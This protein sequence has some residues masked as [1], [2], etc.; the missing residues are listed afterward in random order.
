MLFVLPPQKPGMEELTIW[1]QHTITLNKVSVCFFSASNHQYVLCFVFLPLFENFGIKLTRNISQHRVQGGYLWCIGLFGAQRLRR[2]A[3]V[4]QA[5]RFSQRGRFTAQRPVGIHSDT[6][7]WLLA[8]PPQTR[9]GWNVLLLRLSL[10]WISGASL[11]S[12]HRL[13]CILLCRLCRRLM[14]LLNVILS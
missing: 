7:C 12:A 14:Y 11:L 9:C 6:P 1:E 13:S 8:L 2:R 10:H 4:R 3:A 5:S